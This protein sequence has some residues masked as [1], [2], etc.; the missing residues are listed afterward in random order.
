MASGR[1][2]GHRSSAYRLPSDSQADA[3]RPSWERPGLWKP[4]ILPTVTYPPPTRSHLFIL[5][6]QFPKLGTECLLKYMG[7][8]G[9]FLFKPPQVGSTAL[10]WGAD[11]LV[12]DVYASGYKILHIPEF[13]RNFIVEQGPNAVPFMLLQG[14]QKHLPSV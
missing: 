12:C 5:P 6:K 3:V 8:C 11:K 14:P 13:L 1:Q 2:A 9:S 4:Q 7:L 10:L